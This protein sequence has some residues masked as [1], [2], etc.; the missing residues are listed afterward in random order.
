MKRV[1][2]FTKLANEVE[3]LLGELKDAH[4]PE[5]QELRNRADDALIAAKRAIGHQSDKVSARIAQY[6]G[7]VDKYINDYPRLA[8]ISGALIF[9]TIGYLVGATARER[10]Q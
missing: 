8:F 1:K 5:V 7:S 6:A 3:E 10:E 2:H 4:G 9:G